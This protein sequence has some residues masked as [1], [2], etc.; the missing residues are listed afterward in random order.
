M[1]RRFP[2]KP[3]KHT[4]PE[5][6]AAWKEKEMNHLIK[7]LWEKGYSKIEIEREVSRKFKIR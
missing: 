6:K 1:A 3:Y 2:F 7:Q 4:T 5:F